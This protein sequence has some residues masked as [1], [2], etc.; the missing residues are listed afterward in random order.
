MFLFDKKI[1]LPKSIGTL[2][3]M[4]VNRFKLYFVQTASLS[5]FGLFKSHHDAPSQNS[6]H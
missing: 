2:F 4:N 1:F 6:L 5:R 3:C